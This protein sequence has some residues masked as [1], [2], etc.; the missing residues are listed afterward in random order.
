MIFGTFGVRGGPGDDA[1]HQAAVEEDFP[2]EAVLSAEMLQV[3]PH[4][5]GLAWRKHGWKLTIAKYSRQLQA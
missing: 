5:V 2:R 3:A 1:A 4:L